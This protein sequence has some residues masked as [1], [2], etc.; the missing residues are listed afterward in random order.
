M[1]VMLKQRMGSC[2]LQGRLMVSLLACHGGL[3]EADGKMNGMKSR[4]TGIGLK[5]GV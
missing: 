3:V 5:S 2:D 1:M 4:C